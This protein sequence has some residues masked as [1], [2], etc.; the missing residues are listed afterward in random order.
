MRAVAARADALVD[1]ELPVPAPGPRDLLVAVRAVGVNPVDVKVRKRAGDDAAKVLGWDAA[2]IVMET[3]R[4]VRRFRAGDAVYFAG[5]ITRA[6][7]NSELCIV[8]ERLAGAKPRTLDFAQ[9]AAMPLTLLTA[10]EA[11]FQRMGLSAGGGDGKRLLVVGG[12]GG[13]GSIAIQLAK[14]LTKLTV[15]ATASRPESRAWV[16]RLGADHVVGHDAETIADVDYLLCTTDTEP[17]LGRALQLVAPRGVAC[18]IVAPTR[19]LDL[20]LAAQKSITIAWELMFTRSMF[21]TA[22][23]GE[24]GRI[25]DEMGAL[26]DTGRLA[27]TLTERLT[28]ICAATLQQAHAQLATRATIGKLVV[29]GWPPARESVLAAS[30][31]SR[32]R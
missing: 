30:A 20:A 16:Q 23:M 13:V 29:E 3:G 4:E 22:D 11:L 2:G 7:A 32:T 10:Y 15:I 8:D 6:G 9:A 28:P 5:D 25:L 17:Y 19:P 21:Q 1:L 12:A 27:C 26:L 18:F 14:V 24:Q 31:G